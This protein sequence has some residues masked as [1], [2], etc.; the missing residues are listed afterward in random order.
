MKR[1]ILLCCGLLLSLS[2]I[3]AQTD[4][5]TVNNESYE[6]KTDV[7]GPITLLW[8]VFNQEYRYFAKK[9]NTIIELTNTKEGKNYK[10]EYKKAIS[11]FHTNYFKCFF[12]LF[13]LDSGSASLF[14]N[15]FR[16]S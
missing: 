2:T 9:G 4:T 1:F 8:N 3:T 7:D 10:E 15:S 14:I 5:Y 16:C 13:R 6:L 11:E 12:N